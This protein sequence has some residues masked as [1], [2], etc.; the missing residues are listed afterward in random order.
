MQIDVLM[1]ELV[2]STMMEI[3]EE[4]VYAETRLGSVQATSVEKRKD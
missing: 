3:G 2:F 1:G 4:H